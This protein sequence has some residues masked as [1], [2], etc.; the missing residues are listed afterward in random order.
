MNGFNSGLRDTVNG[1]A[2]TI[3]SVEIKEE[4]RNSTIWFYD[5]WGCSEGGVGAIN[6]NDSGLENFDA[7]VRNAKRLNGTGTSSSLGGSVTGQPTSTRPLP[8]STAAGNSAE[9][10]GESTLRAIS[11]FIP[12]LLA[13]F[14]A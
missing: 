8:T 7:F 12:F 5:I 9:R 1:S 14:A 11:I 10:T 6:A 2:N 4:D 13:M 3:L